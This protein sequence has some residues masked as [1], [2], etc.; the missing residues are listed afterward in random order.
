[1]FMD[2][3]LGILSFCIFSHSVADVG[4]R[5]AFGIT[6]VL[7]IVAFQFVIT[8]SLP[9]VNYLTLIDKYNLF[10]FSF[11]AVQIVE[12]AK[13][14][15]NVCIVIFVLMFVVGHFWFAFTAYQR[16]KYEWTKKGIEE[17]INVW[18]V[19]QTNTRE[20]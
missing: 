2:V 4:D 5:L 11:T 16:N 17:K 1:M 13:E 8:S 10:I 20:E 3:F 19:Q 9:T 14:A 12:S 6:M 15:D 7:T 18:F